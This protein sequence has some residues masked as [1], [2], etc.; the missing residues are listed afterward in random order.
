[1]RDHPRVDAER[2][3]S[4]APVLAVDDD[5]VEAREERSPELLL[6]RR[7]ARQE[8]V[9]GEHR[10]RVRPEEPRVDLRHEPLHVQDVRRADAERREP[11]GMLGDLQRQPQP[12]AA[13]EP[14][15]HADRRARGARS[16]PARG[17]S[18]KRKCDVTSSTSA[19]ARASAAA[20]SWSY[21]GVKAGGSARTIRTG[22]GYACGP[23]RSHVE[24]LPRQ[25]PPARAARVPAAR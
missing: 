18:P 9:R 1:M 14:R 15:R 12:R 17:A 23:A 6:R 7:P 21:A 16:R 11:E 10:G 19:P 3:E 24:S 25:R 13:E 8:V 20:S 5:A 22:L 2:R 4:V